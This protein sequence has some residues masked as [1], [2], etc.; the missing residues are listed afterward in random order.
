MLHAIN[1]KAHFSMT[2]H[3]ATNP[4]D[5]KAYDFLEALYGRCHGGGDIVFIGSTRNRVSAVYRVDQ[6]DEAAD[7]IATRPLDLFQKINVMDH[8]ATLKRNA[9]GIGGV[10]EVKAVVAIA[11]D[12]DAGEKNAEK[13]ATQA[14]LL[15]A[16][17]A[18]PL[19]PSL[20]ILSDGDDKGFHAYWL[21]DEP[22]YISD[23]A[24]R[25]RCSALSQGWLEE[26][27]RCVATVHSAAT[28]DG[29]ANL[30]R[31]LRPIGTLRKSGNVVRAL[32]WNPERR[33]RLDDFALPEA[34]KPTAATTE[35][36]VPSEGEYIIERYLAAQ[37]MDSVEAI[38]A[39]H[40]YTRWQGSDRF[41]IRPG[42]SSGAP[43]GEVF[44]VDG[45]EGFTVKSGAADPLSC[46]NSRGA[47]GNWYSLPAL[48]L[49]LNFGV[50]AKQDKGVWMQGA[51]FCHDFLRAPD[52]QVDWNNLTS[53]TSKAANAQPLVN[54]V[55]VAGG[56]TTATQ[57]SSLLPPAAV[58]VDWEP[59]DFVHLR[60]GEQ[61]ERG[62]EIIEGILRDGEVCFIGSQS[63]AG[64]SWLVGNLIW[65][66]ISGTP[67]LGHN[68]KQ[69]RVL[70]IDNELKPREIDWR[71]TQIARALQFEPKAGMLT[72][73]CRRGK[74]CDIRGVALAIDQ[75]DLSGYSL[76]VL[77]AVYKTIPDGKSENGNEE[78]GKL[79][80]TLQGIAERTGVAAVCVHHATK[81]DQ[82]QKSTLDILA[83]AGSFGRSLD[84]MIA[85]RDH[86]QVGL[87]VIEYAC[88][89]N[90]SPDPISVKFEWPLWHA[91]TTTP[92]LRKR[93]TSGE[94]AQARKDAEADELVRGALNSKRNVSERQ[95]RRMTGLGESR[96]QRSLARLQAAGEI[97]QRRVVRNGRKL[98]V[99]QMGGPASGPDHLPDQ[100]DTGPDGPRTYL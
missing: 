91:V 67:W 95:L 45:R 18:M 5:V 99:Y 50:D 23:E 70:L 21:L 73:I 2:A 78:M 30:D 89:T 63:K 90:P 75:M 48:W 28:V 39:P 52:V 54:T 98:E 10:A 96:V 1:R 32:K 61:L 100:G 46:I 88:R 93:P 76:I 35:R 34:V 7:H 4:A 36:Y 72:T 60:E 41:L 37:G 15:E 27:R 62:E 14:Q 66:A 11:L 64:K 94:A 83:G 29:T 44:N 13:Y 42:A 26:L 19:V 49:S 24:D 68:V 81:G 97:K 82:S 17:D 86:E 40:G 25:S 12:V 87:N 8:A 6:L 74:G 56:T 31:Y 84:T 53:T 38:L 58:L 16:L 77:D 92:E 51:K 9:S 22:H 80:D 69:G 55:Q 79:M 47:V 33:Y 3:L 59:V 65:S 71:H 85:L 20:I 57:Y 43:T